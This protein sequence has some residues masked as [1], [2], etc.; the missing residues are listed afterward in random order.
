MKERNERDFEASFGISYWKTK[1]CPEC[2]TYKVPF[3]WTGAHF[4]EK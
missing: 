2:G 1:T 3:Y 4:C